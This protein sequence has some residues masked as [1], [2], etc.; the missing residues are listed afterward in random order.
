MSVVRSHVLAT[1]LISEAV[2]L[3]KPEASQRGVE[4]H[5]TCLCGRPPVLLGDGGRVRQIMVNLMS[6]AVKFTQ[7]GSVISIVCGIDSPP[8]GSRL[9]AEPHV[10]MRVVDSGPG[11]PEEKL[12][13]IFQPFVQLDTALTRTHGGS[14]LGLAISRQLAQL[15]KGHITVTSQRGIGSTFTLW[16]PTGEESIPVIR[17][18]TPRV[19]IHAVVTASFYRRRGELRRARGHEVPLR[20]RGRSSADPLRA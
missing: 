5:E 9:P 18:H 10:F 14:G 8:V 17:A 20:N 3:L 7:R 6:N 2:R 11:I 16:L 4:L 19:G 15:M 12:E 1:T 13:A